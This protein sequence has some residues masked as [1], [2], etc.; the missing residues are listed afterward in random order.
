MEQEPETDPLIGR[1]ING[2]FTVLS[3]IARGGMGKVYKAEQAPLGRICAL[4]VLNPKYQGDEDP[5]FQKRFYLEASTAAKLNHPNTV[6]IFDYGRDGDIYYI[7][8]EYIAGRT[9]YR[10]LRE[11]GPFSEGRAVH[12]V[13]QV[14]RSLREAH[15]IGVI[16]RDLKPANVLLFDK[17]DETD[18][19]KVLDFGLVK[20]VTGKEGEELTQ[21]GLFM[22]SPKY[23]APEQIL[24]NPVSARTDIYSLGVVLYEI[25]AGSPPFDRGGSVKTL[26]AHVNEDPPPLEQFNPHL[27]IGPEMRAVLARC[28]EKA[29]EA[30]FGSM[31]ELMVALSHIDAAP[32]T[33]SLRQAPRLPSAAS[34]MEA[35][36]RRPSDRTPSSSGIVRAGASEAPTSRSKSPLIPPVPVPVEATA[37]GGDSGSLTPQPLAHLAV[38]PADLEPPPRSRKGAFIGVAAVVAAGIAVAV[39]VVTGTPSPNT[40]ASTAAAPTGQVAAPATTTAEAATTAATEKSAAPTAEVKPTASA[41]AGR[42]VH[43]VSTPAGAKVME[44]KKVLCE[45]TPC[46]VTFSGDDAKAEHKLTFS[47]DGFESV[48]QKLDRTSDKL[49]SE[50]KKALPASVFVPP[51]PVTKGVT[52][53]P[54]TSAKTTPGYKPSPYD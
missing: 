22:G 18:I 4:K 36:N 8:M 21:A 11:E 20:D 53:P 26:M 47:L 15:Q 7:A 19:V 34:L 31:E 37:G 48:D 54:P 23:M 12:V 28:L 25:L 43:I 40:T 24:G 6:T 9:L 38:Q 51:P 17:G 1:S 50:L 33:E 14:C 49:A 2:R 29:P 46:D 35:A 39:V 30:R 10:A 13:R 44:G 52:P 32:L 27:A 16:H 45:A 41:D 3:V 5:E 42:S